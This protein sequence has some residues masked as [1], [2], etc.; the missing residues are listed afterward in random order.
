M[1]RLQ[2]TRSVRHQHLISNA[3]TKQSAVSRTWEVSHRKDDPRESERAVGCSPMQNQF[4]LLRLGQIIGQVKWCWKS[5]F[6]LP[7]PLPTYAF[8]QA[9]VIGSWMTLLWSSLD[10]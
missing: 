9:A 2:R 5:T 4:I 3:A 8:G 10:H 1:N 7:A 6:R